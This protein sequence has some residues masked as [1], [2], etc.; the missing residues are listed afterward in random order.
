MKQ[1]LLVDDNDKYAQLLE[2]YFK[3]L[4]FK[5][6]RACDAAE[7]LKKFINHN[8][9]FYNLIVTDVTM[10]TQTSG[11]GMLKRIKKSGYKGTII[12]ASTGFDVLTAKTLTKMFLRSTGV[13]YMI[14]KTTVL[15][16]KPVYYPIN[17]FKKPLYEFPGL[18]DL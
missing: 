8:P 10:E 2:D 3:E 18:V 14:P 7:G 9:D 12:I 6:D 15:T 11:L 4:G 16:K 17:F 1:L 13:H 5:A